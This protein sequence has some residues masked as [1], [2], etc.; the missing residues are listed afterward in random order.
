MFLTK[1]GNKQVKKHTFVRIKG[2]LNINDRR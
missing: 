1:Y 2:E